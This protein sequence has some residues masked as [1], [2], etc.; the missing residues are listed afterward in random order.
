MQHK[1]GYQLHDRMLLPRS[2]ET[3]VEID[4]YRRRGGPD[5][6]WFHQIWHPLEVL[7]RIDSNKDWSSVVGLGLYRLD[8]QCGANKRPRTC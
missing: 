1:L 4:V 2:S 6:T 5:S 7:A 8:C 3:G